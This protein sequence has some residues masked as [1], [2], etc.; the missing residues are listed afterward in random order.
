VE[1]R[2]AEEAAA[3]ALKAARL[4]SLWRTAK[5][6]S[7]FNLQRLQ[8]MN[9]P[10]VPIDQLERQECTI[11]RLHQ[12]EC[13]DTDASE[14]FEQAPGYFSHVY[15]DPHDNIVTEEQEVENLYSDIPR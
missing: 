11:D 9:G 3:K 7:I 4:R 14:S 10:R 8:T 1:R 5:E 6:K 2:L 12:I 13:Q 15:L